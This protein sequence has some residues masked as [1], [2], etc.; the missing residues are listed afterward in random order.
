NISNV[1]QGIRDRNDLGHPICSHL[2]QGDW[3]AHYLTERLAKLPHNSN[4]LITKAIIQMSDILKI[5]YKPLS[6]IP[7]YLVPAYFEALTVTLTEFIKL[8]VS[9]ASVSYGLFFAVFV[10]VFVRLS[11]IY[12]KIVTF[13]LCKA[14]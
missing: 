12:R 11:L 6:N 8:E 14:K 9:S 4:K 13:K 1:L 5:M 10:I 3:L 2:R 7:R